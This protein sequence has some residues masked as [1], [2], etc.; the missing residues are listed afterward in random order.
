[1]R[2]EWTANLVYPNTEVYVFLAG[3]NE[4]AKVYTVATGGTA[5]ST[6]PQVTSGA[7]GVASFYVDTTDYDVDQ[8]F[9]VTVSLIGTNFAWSN[10][11]MKKII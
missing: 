4:P 1:M 9:D 3:S 5:I 7:I 8:Q 10:V 6:L 2:S 11:Y